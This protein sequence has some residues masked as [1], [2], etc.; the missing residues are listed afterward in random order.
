MNAVTAITSFTVNG[1]WLTLCAALYALM[2]SAYACASAMIWL[3]TFFLYV[4]T[5]RSACAV[6]RASAAALGVKIWMLVTSENA[7][8]FGTS[9]TATRA[10]PRPIR[11]RSP[12]SRAVAHPAPYA[13]SA[14][15]CP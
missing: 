3:P 12:R 5:M 1:A 4:L 8:M 2:P 10:A 6:T 13:T 9:A 7:S 14:C 11:R 15:V